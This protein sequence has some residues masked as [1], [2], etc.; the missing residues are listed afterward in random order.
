MSAVTELNE[1][2][3]LETGCWSEQATRLHAGAAGVCGESGE[4]GG[5]HCTRVP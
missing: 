2:C 5:Q 1:E 4:Q 3:L